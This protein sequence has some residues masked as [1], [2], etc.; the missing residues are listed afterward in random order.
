M[1]T[2]DTSGNARVSNDAETDAT[3]TATN[4]HIVNSEAASRTA[5]ETIGPRKADNGT[6]IRTDAL[7]A[8]AIITGSAYLVAYLFEI[9]CANV[10]HIP[11]ELISL[12]IQ[13]IF[14]AIVGLLLLGYG[15]PVVMVLI[16]P[17]ISVAFRERHYYMTARVLP[18]AAATAALSFF[19]TPIFLWFASLAAIMYWTKRASSLGVDMD[20]KD[21]KDPRQAILL[22]MEMCIGRAGIYFLIGMLFAISAP[23]Y[24]GWCLASHGYLEWASSRENEVIVGVYG[25]NVVVMP[26]EST[27]DRAPTLETVPPTPDILYLLSLRYQNPKLE[28]LALK[29]E[30]RVYKLGDKDTPTFRYNPELRSVSVD[31]NYRASLSHA[32]YPW[33]TVFACVLMYSTCP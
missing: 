18:A 12:S 11:Q 5:D 7:S 28:R 14:S 33:T 16:F 29:P 1:D 8:T 17:D 26:L 10:F 20:A 3:P 32:P 2:G 19:I 9:G 25:D 15:F 30:L 4:Q 13:S 6:L 23:T 24:L 31:W 22:A 21:A 27:R